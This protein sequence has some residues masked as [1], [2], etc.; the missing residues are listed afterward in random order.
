MKRIKDKNLI[1]S[2]FQPS[3]VLYEEDNLIDIW[4]EKYTTEQISV[5]I[6]GWLASDGCNL[7]LVKETSSSIMDENKENRKARGIKRPEIRAWLRNKILSDSVESA[8]ILRIEGKKPYRKY[9]YM[10]SIEPFLRKFLEENEIDIT[11]QRF[12]EKSLI[13]LNLA[14]KWERY[15]LD[16]YGDEYRI[17]FNLGKNCGTLNPKITLIF[18]NARKSVEVIQRKNRSLITEEVCISIAAKQLWR[19]FV[20]RQHA[21]LGDRFSYHLM[22]DKRFASGRPDSFFNQIESSCNQ[23]KPDIQE[24]RDSGDC[25]ISIEHICDYNFCQKCD[26]EPDFLE[27]LIIVALKSNISFPKWQNEESGLSKIL[28][29][30]QDGILSEK[31]TIYKLRLIYGSVNDAYTSRNNKQDEFL[32]QVKFVIDKLE[33]GQNIKQKKIEVPKTDMFSIA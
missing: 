29:M 13:K 16:R 10:D 4:G 21:Y 6:C 20:S 17:Y 5:C 28:Y 11:H 24:T 12:Y 30:I 15:V 25:K 31:D 32:A 7:T 33:K 3:P 27:N 22:T 9:I 23:K 14:E 8:G 19:P 2:V 26:I 18:S 1:K